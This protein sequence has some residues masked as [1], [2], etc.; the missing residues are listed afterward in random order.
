MH[1]FLSRYNRFYSFVVHR[2]LLTLYA[3]TVTIITTIVAV[4]FLACYLLFA[5]KIEVAQQILHSDNC[6]L[7]SR[8]KTQKQCQILTDDIH[9]LKKKIQCE[10]HQNSSSTQSLASLMDAARHSDF[11]LRDCT[12]GVCRKKKKNTQQLIDCV[13]SATLDQLI[14]FFDYLHTQKIPVKCMQLDMQGGEPYEVRL[15]L[16][17]Y[18][19]KESPSRLR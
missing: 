13:F 9:R 14:V 17:M 1:Y 19:I 3:I 11:V 6:F 18:S 16:K 5:K 15:S 7:E 2:R 10:Y 4:W 8:N 12:L